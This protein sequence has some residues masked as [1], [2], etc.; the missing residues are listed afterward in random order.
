VNWLKNIF[1][2]KPSPVSKCDDEPVRAAIR[3]TILDKIATREAAIACAPQAPTWTDDD[4]IDFGKFLNSM[5]G[6]R[7]VAKA[8]AMEYNRAITLPRDVFHTQHCAGQVT[9]ISDTITWMLS[10][11]Q[12]KLSEALA[13]SSANTA[14]DAH[15]DEDALLKQYSP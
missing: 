9:G 10:L 11:A 8:R 7:F 13:D 15:Q 12:I 2:K 14:A 6:Q 5:T 1:G 4:I 3:R